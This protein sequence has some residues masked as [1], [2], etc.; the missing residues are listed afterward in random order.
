MHDEN[1]YRAPAARIDDETRWP[2]H[3]A[4]RWRRWF[5]W[6][7]DSLAMVVL[8]T[9]IIIAGELAGGEG[10]MAW[11]EELDTWQNYLLGIPVSTTH[12][13]TGSIIGAG[14][15]RRASAVR[16][17]VASNVVAAWFITIP[18]SALVAAAFYAVTRF[19]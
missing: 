8:W 15:A 13:I 18:A 14:V 12:T 6:V 11:V 1:P 17:G 16:W 19:F 7:I 10:T 4:G 5:N 9:L 2:I 3:A